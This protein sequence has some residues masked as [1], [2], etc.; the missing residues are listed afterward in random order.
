MAGISAFA[1]L[2]ISNTN[3]DFRLVLP[4]S[5][6]IELETGDYTLFYEHQSLLNGVVYTTDT[7]VPGIRFFV[8]APDESGVELTTPSVN[9]D[10]ELEGRAGY[11]VVHFTVDETGMYTVGGNYPDGPIGAFFIFALG[12]SS[13]GP[14]LLALFSLIGGVGISAVLT[15]S[16]FVS[17]RRS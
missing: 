14:L 13:S 1:V 10:Y 12:K 9:E 17:R 3:P 4:G 15:I 7:T 8:M 5:Q 11:S 2:Q 6:E 16:T